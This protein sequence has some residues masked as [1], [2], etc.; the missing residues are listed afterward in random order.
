M[1]GDNKIAPIALEILR[2]CSGM[3]YVY[4]KAGL[5]DSNL[6]FDAFVFILSNHLEN[7]IPYWSIAL[8]NTLLYLVQYY[9]RMD[10]ITTKILKDM[11]RDL[12]TDQKEILLQVLRKTKENTRKR[13]IEH[14]STTTSSPEMMNHQESCSTSPRKKLRASLL[15]QVKTQLY[16]ERTDEIIKESLVR[17]PVSNKTSK[18]IMDAFTCIIKG[19]GLWEESEIFHTLTCLK[20]F[21]YGDE[22]KPSLLRILYVDYNNNEFLLSKE[23]A[24]ADMLLELEE[25]KVKKII[26]IFSNKAEKRLKKTTHHTKILG[27]F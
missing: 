24:W 9:S 22:E 11:I 4:T 14:V 3:C 19:V 13:P 10:S 5:N 6:L 27:L 1:E 12:N 15:K 26:V 8:D 17:I 25:N 2:L 16:K 18:G 21:S 7:N 20:S 23:V